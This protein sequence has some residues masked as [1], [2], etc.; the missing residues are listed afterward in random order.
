MQQRTQVAEL[1]FDRPTI[2][3]FQYAREEETTCNLNLI[4]VTG[5]TA[6][7]FRTTHIWQ[8]FIRINKHVSV[9]D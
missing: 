4:S 7:T 3:S 6:C 5:L 1:S 9:T 8:Y 2:N